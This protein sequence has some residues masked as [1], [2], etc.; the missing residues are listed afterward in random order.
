MR[1]LVS[2]LKETSRYLNDDAEVINE[3]YVILK[4]RIEREAQ[5]L[6]KEKRAEVPPPEVEAPKAPEQPRLKDFNLQGT[7]TQMK[8][9]VDVKDPKITIKSVIL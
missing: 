5:K 9:T 3:D 2:Q 4:I 8:L 6:A 7:A 1:T